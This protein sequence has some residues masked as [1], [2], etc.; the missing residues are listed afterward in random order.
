[1]QSVLPLKVSKV[2]PRINNRDDDSALLCVKFFNFSGLDL[3]CKTQHAALRVSIQPEEFCLR[4][5]ATRDIRV[6]MQPTKQE[7]ARCK[8]SPA[9]IG[10]LA[11]FY[12]DEITRQQLRR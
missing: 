10:A 6:V 5:G 11:F 7:V 8:Q 12:G 9:I 1:M 3:T 4:A 2:A